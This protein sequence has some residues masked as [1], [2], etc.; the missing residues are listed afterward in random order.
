MIEA[1]LLTLNDAPALCM[2]QRDVAEQPSANIH[3]L[4][5][6]LTEYSQAL[7][8]LRQPEHWGSSASQRCL[9][10][11]HAL[12]ARPK[13]R[14]LELDCLWVVADMVLTFDAVLQRG[15][16]TRGAAFPYEPQNYN[17]TGDS[18]RGG[19]S[20]SLGLIGINL[21]YHTHALG[22]GVAGPI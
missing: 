3:L 14:R 11:R 4:V 12:Q 6:A 19:G 7:P 10:L 13:P 21:S 16:A 1:I 22:G 9:R 2:R 5:A 18:G 20:G 15:Q 8:R 17:I